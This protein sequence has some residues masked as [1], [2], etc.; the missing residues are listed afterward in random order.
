[1]V[2]WVGDM[3]VAP[4]AWDADSEGIRAAFPDNTGLVDELPSCSARE[5]EHFAGLLDR[6]SL[7]D[8][9]EEQSNTS[10]GRNA[11]GVNRY[12][13]YNH[14]NRPKGIGQRIDLV[15]TNMPMGDPGGGEAVVRSVKVLSEFKGSDH[16]PV[17]AEIELTQ[18]ANG[19]VRS[20]GT[21]GNSEHRSPRVH[22][23]LGPT[24]KGHEGPSGA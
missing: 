5:R 7:V 1:M 22:D 3:N 18:V 2:V 17:E 11:V 15:L 13:Q 19:A 20:T 9:F 8:A 14:E 16:V 23:R 24:G 21:R 4:R 12:T 6:L 10:L